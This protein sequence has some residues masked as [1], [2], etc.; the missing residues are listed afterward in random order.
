M[1]LTDTHCHL[2]FNLFDT[3]R[4]LVVE[5][6]RDA[7]LDRILDPGIDL[8]SSRNSIRLAE[9]FD[10]VYAAVGVHPNEAEKWSNT[11]LSELKEMA[12]APRVVAIGEIG[13]DYYRGQAWRERQLRDISRAARPGSRV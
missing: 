8:E 11:S 5:R 1:A 9:M 12:S 10:I 13:L 6:A 7:G 4:S 2:D 3:D